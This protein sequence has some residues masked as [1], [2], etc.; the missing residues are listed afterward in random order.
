[1]Y[2]YILFIILTIIG[3]IVFKDIIISI[4]FSLCLTSI[5]DYFYQKKFR[6]KKIIEKMSNKKKRKHN[7][8]RKRKDK[9]KISRKTNGEKDSKNLSSKLLKQYKFPKGKYK[10]D[11]KQSYNKTYNS[12]SKGQVKGLNK[13]TKQLVKTQERLMSTLR[14]M[15]PVLEQGKNIIGAFDSFFGDGGDNKN[16]LNYMKNRLGI[17]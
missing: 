3:Y 13:D 11:P 16:D 17:K 4:L 6:S 15:G 7:R 2:N 8:K 5:Y 10:F 12:L 9:S 1:M 14:D